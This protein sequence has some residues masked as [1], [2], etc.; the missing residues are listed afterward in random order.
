MDMGDYQTAIEELT[1]ALEVCRI[2]R[3]HWN[4]EFVLFTGWLCNS[5]AV[6]Q[7][8]DFVRFL[9]ESFRFCYI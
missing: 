6:E 1:K 9:K 4:F 7:S 5:D 2:R 8:K 3:L